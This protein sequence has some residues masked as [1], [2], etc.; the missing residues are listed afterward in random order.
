VCTGHCTVQC[1]VH[2][3]PR[4]QNS[5]SCVLSGGSPDNYCALSGVH[6]TCTVDCPVRPY[7]VFR[8][9]FPCPSPRP[10][11]VSSLA[12]A[13][14][15]LWRHPLRSGDPSLTGGD[16]SGDLQCSC[17]P[18]L[19]GEHHLLSLSSLSVSAVSSPLHPFVP[20]SNF[21]QIL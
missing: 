1:P 4:A 3:Q 7:S 10:G 15:G 14:L 19:S 6:R 18:S 2:W 11:S 12:T 8:K 21:Y 9:P 13:S 17:F 16:L 5:F 20:N